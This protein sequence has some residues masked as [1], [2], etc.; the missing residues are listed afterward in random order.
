MKTRQLLPLILFLFIVSNT[1]AKQE[2]LK[3]KTTTGHQKAANT[4]AKYTDEEIKKM[5]LSNSTYGSDQKTATPYSNSPQGGP[6]KAKKD[7]LVTP[8][9]IDGIP[10]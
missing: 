7:E 5:K 10:K 1:F 6:V 8:K 2:P 4:D 9:I 3:K